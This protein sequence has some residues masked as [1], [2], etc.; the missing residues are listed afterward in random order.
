M[1][2]VNVRWESFV[3]AVKQWQSI[4]GAVVGGIFSLLVAI[5]VG[6]IIR[7]REDRASGML[8]AGSLVPSMGRKAV[9]ESLM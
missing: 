5:I 6:H 2:G 3:E 9:L 4:T 8:L 7:R 1:L